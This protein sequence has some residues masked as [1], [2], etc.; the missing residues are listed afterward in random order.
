[1]VKKNAEIWGKMMHVFIML[2][3]IV[4][5]AIYFSPVF[6]GKKIQQSDITQWR[7]M[8][9]SVSDFR[10]KTGEEPLWTNSMFGGMPAYMI[11]AK[12]PGNISSQINSIYRSL[13]HPV[14]M[15]ILYIIGYYFLLLTLGINK[16]QSL[17][18]AIAYGFS[19][20]LLIIIGVGHNTKAYAIGYMAPV[21]AGIIMTFE[22]R[23]IS[24]SLLFT[25]ALSLQ[26]HSNHYQITYYTLILVILYGLVEIIYAIKNKRILNFAANVGVL[27]LGI[28]LAIGMN[29]SRLYTTWEY[30]K[31]TI[32]GQSELLAED[33]NK[34]RGLDRDYVF[35]HS[36]G[37]DE[38]LTLLIPS[39]KG[40]SSLLIPGT[41]SEVFKKTRQN[42]EKARQSQR[43]GQSISYYYGDKPITYGP[44]YIGAIVVFLFVLGLF[45][46]RGPYLWWL[47]IATVISIVLAWGKN[48]LGLSDFLLDYL[49]LYSK[50]RAPDMILVIAGFT[51]PLLGF[52]GLNRI[53]SGQVK[54]KDI[55]ESTVSS[56]IITGGFALLY[57][58]FP[59]ISGDFTGINDL[60]INPDWLLDSIVIDRKN[61][62]QADAFRS[63][64]FIV[65]AAGS[66]Y[67][68]YLNKIK[69]NGLI[70]LLGTLI[71]IDLWAVDKRYFNESNFSSKRETQNP[72]P[73]TLADNEILKDQDISFRV[74]QLKDPFTDARA[75]YYH[76]NVGGYHAAKL[77]RYQ[78]LIDCCIN[79][80]LM[81]ISNGLRLGYLSDSILLK[82]S[83]LNMLNTRYLINDL[84]I[85]PIKNKYA[86]GNAWFVNNY[87]IVNNPDEELAT[88][89]LVDPKTIAIVD[90]DFE[91][92]IVDKSFSS[93]SKNR[94]VMVENQP[95]YLKYSYNASSEQFTVFSEIYYDKGW[96]AYIDGEKADYF[97]ANYVLRAMVIPEGD[98]VVEFKFE[99]KS[100]TIGNKISY[101]SSSL[102]ILI[103]LGYC[104]FEIKRW[105]HSR[106][107]EESS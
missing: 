106:N 51:M 65:L 57:A 3:I 21:I 46:V 97:R 84:N 68:W 48:V 20:Y 14:G 58:L 29:F 82:M 8:S 64:V 63:F 94:I 2:F 40:G 88:L 4:L 66:I 45:I 69:S 7:A 13:F 19:T 73:K 67:L 79:R 43:S 6:E 41:N 5:S 15:L 31:Q 38:T 81:Q 24:G 72:F 75:S 90:K 42:I 95:N 56:L 70:F 32:R 25:V 1:M 39:F 78:E 102:M 74:L 10:D 9:K 103:F 107:K 77:G 87:H 26:L 17:A 93:E 61:M 54:K 53:L 33:A 36:Q 50:F 49:P 23:K 60:R 11:S 55:F 27:L 83:V 44:V 105:K 91:D 59:A 104:Y 76:Q 100:Y 47:L 85:P 12:Y 101:A 89:R 62:L 28:I 35:E 98:H 16:W 80:E 92:Y 52:I 22:G 37:I 18:G 86:M 96:N 30:S 99:P 34:T 71:I